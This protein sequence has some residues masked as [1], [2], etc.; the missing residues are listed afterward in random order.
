MYDHYRHR[1][2]FLHSHKASWGI[3]IQHQLEF[4]SD[5]LQHRVM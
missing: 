2:K 1:V 3:I 4:V 5:D